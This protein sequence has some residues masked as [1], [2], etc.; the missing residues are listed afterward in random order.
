MTYG[1]FEIKVPRPVFTV[2][3]DYDPDGYLGNKREHVVKIDAGG[4][5]LHE[6][7]FT[8]EYDWGAPEGHRRPAHYVNDEEGAAD[9]AI[10]NFGKRLLAL[11]NGETK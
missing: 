3:V 5:E 9:K 10:A 2:E 1:T 11:L 4:I 6:E 8:S 7:R